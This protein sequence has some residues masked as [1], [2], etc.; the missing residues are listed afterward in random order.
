M[1]NVM[2]VVEFNVIGAMA[3]VETACVFSVPGLA[4]IQMAGNVFSAMVQ[5]NPNAACVMVMDMTIATIVTEMA[6]WFV[7]VA[8]ALA[9]YAAENVMVKEM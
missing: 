6:M 2:G 5:E 7:V 4:V 8:M 1:M 9:N 3:Q